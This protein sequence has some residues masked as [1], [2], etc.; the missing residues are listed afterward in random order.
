MNNIRA[1]VFDVFGTVVDWRTSIADAVAPLIRGLDLEVD[2][3]HFA[4]LWRR[5]YQPAMA[6]I[7]EGRREFTRL[8][9][10]H[11]ENLEQVLLELGVSEADRDEADLAA[12]NSAWHKLTPWPDVVPALG[13]LKQGYII[14]PMSNANISMMIDI[15]KHAQLPWDAILGA[16]VV[17]AYKPAPQAYT[18]TADVLGIASHQICLVAAH[19]YDLEAARSCGWMTAFV[20]RRSEHGPNQTS[21]L[22]PESDWD[23]IA[24]D[25]SNLAAQLG[26]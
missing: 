6:E 15:S 19:N 10:L 14:A 21:D 25:F 7:R 16:E 9:T 23:F 24:D 17:G 18:R 8:D 12:I 3:D 20:P 26:C 5:R 1:V 22:V 2:P 11:R 4:D 13:R